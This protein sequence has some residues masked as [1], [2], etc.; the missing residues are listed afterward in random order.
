MRLILQVVW[1]IGIFRAD[2]SLTLTKKNLR[3]IRIRVKVR[4]S[5][6]LHTTEVLLCS[7]DFHGEYLSYILCTTILQYI[8]NRTSTEYS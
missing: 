2:I 6:H 4:S 8:L 1:L 3:F 7:K 5:I